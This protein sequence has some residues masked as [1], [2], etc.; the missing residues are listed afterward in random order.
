MNSYTTSTSDSTGGVTWQYTEPI[1]C[2]PP[3]VIPSVWIP[4]EKPERKNMRYLFRIT[5]VDPKTEEIE[6]GP[7][8]VVAKDRSEVML[9]A[10]IAQG[11]RDRADDYDFIIEQVGEV[12]PKR[13]TQKV[14]IAKEE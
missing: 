11:L 5:V 14:T 2:Q 7:M 4:A 1:H 3:I 6:D 8:F 9:K 12:R 10:P 13:E